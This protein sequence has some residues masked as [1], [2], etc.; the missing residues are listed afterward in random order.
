MMSGMFRGTVWAGGEAID[1]IMVAVTG[2]WLDLGDGYM[3][4]HFYN[5]TCRCVTLPMIKK[6]KS[7]INK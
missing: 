6:K 7:K 5:S 3:G 1:E 2:Q 4:I